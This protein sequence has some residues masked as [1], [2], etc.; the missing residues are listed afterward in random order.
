MFHSIRNMEVEKC[1]NFKALC[2]VKNQSD[3][4][5]VTSLTHAIQ[6]YIN[7]CRSVHLMIKIILLIMMIL[8]MTMSLIM[9]SYR[10]YSGSSIL[11]DTV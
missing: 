3:G 7:R 6:L 8:L 5:R 10:H 2:Q 1:G 9:E 4:G 11:V